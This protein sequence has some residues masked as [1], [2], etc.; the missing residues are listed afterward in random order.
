MPI[1]KK[2]IASRDEIIARGNYS[3][4]DLCEWSMKNLRVS[5]FVESV[6]T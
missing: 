3:R 1:E 5:T 2:Q 4:N 6:F